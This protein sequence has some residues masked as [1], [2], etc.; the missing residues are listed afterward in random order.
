QH[1]MLG[2]DA[3]VGVRDRVTA[4]A[5]E[6][7]EVAVASEHNVVADL[8][9]VVREL[10]LASFLVEIAGNELTTDTSRVPWGHANVFPLPVAE[11]KPRGGA[12][13]VRD[14]TA[15]DVFAEV[16]RG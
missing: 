8:E 3:P 2:A 13:V 1:S 12:S 15:R 9:P 16:R 5:A 7:V 6:G 10:G 11:G 14:R 4:N